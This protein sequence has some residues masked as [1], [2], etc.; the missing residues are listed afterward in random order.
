MACP[1]VRWKV[2]AVPQVPALRDPTQSPDRLRLIKRGAR[3]LWMAIRLP[4]AA[5]PLALE[6]F[7]CLALTGTFVLGTAGALSLRLSGVL[8]G[9]PFW[10]MVALTLANLLVAS[11]YHAVI[12]LLST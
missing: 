3:I 6:P 7:V 10:G 2:N 12:R 11:V 1:I 5:L 8:P 4:A 9:F